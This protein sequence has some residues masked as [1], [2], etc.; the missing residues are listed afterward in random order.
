[1][2]PE[3]Q[4]QQDPN[5]LI[6]GISDVAKGT[7]VNAFKIRIQRRAPGQSY[8]VL[9]AA[10]EDAT[11]DQIAHPESW[12]TRIGGGGTYLITVFHPVDTAKVLNIAPIIVQ[13]GGAPRQEPVDPSIVNEPNWTGPKDMSFPLQQR[14]SGAV[15]PIFGMPSSFGDATGSAPRNGDQPSFGGVPSSPA[16]QF[17]AI[18]VSLEREREDLRQQTLRAQEERHRAEVLAVQQRNELELAKLRAEFKVAAVPV[19]QQ[20]EGPSETATLIVEMNRQSQ[21]S[22][23]RFQALMLELNKG[24]A[25][26]LAGMQETN[27]LLLSKLLDKPAIDP[28]ME[29][30]LAKNADEAGAIVK[31]VTQMAEASGSIVNMMVSAVH[32]ISELNRSPDDAE[33]NWLKAVKIGIEGLRPMLAG[34][35]AQQVQAPPVYQ[36][37]PAQ[38]QSP[39]PRVQPPRVVPSQPVAVPVPAPQPQPQATQPASFGDADGSNLDAFLQIVRAIRERRDPTEVATFFLDNVEEPAVKS[40]LDAA[41]GNPLEALEPHLRDWVGADVQN[42]PYIHTLLKEV[43][44]IYAERQ[45]GREEEEEEE[46]TDGEKL[47]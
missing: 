13:A 29:K 35:Q 17:D 26:Q 25:M 18:R 34:M 42:M 14:R 30:L 2:T 39:R 19:V 37:Q 1:M 5:I 9:L 21:A 32:S 10:F 16:T 20:R 33:P 3:S 4:L 36:P 41:G 46:A 22:A 15:T 28:V 6:S 7:G 12:L 31:V 8:P 38:F 40:R 11:V 24:T 43:E 47:A 44:R 23:D 27:K 45:G